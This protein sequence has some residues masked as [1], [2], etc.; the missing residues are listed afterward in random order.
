MQAADL[1]T[2]TVEAGTSALAE[3]TRL[4]ATPDLSPTVA[5]THKAEGVGI[6]QPT[7]A[8]IVALPTATPAVIPGS[9]QRFLLPMAGLMTVVA[10]VGGVVGALVVLFYRHKQ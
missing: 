1:A 9:L 7:V 3:A 5:P 4:A 2:P 6:G 8:P 10:I